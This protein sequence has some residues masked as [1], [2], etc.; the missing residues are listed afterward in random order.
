MFLC[1]RCTA[2]LQCEQCAGKQINSQQMGH[3]QYSRGGG[4]V[5]Q[6][7]SSP[8]SLG[9]PGPRLER[10]VG[11]P[12]ERGS[13][14]QYENIGPHY[15][16]SSL[17]AAPSPPVPSRHSAR[18]DMI[19]A[20]TR[21]PECFFQQQQAL[22]QRQQL[23]EQLQLIQLKMIQNK[24]EHLK[25][26]EMIQQ[27]AQ[28]PPLQDFHRSPTVQHSGAVLQS[29]VNP[30][31]PHPFPAATPFPVSSTFPQPSTFTSPSSPF[32]ISATTQSVFQVSPSHIPSTPTLSSAFSTSPR[33]DSSSTS[34]GLRTD[35]SVLESTRNHLAQCGWYHG[36][37]SWEESNSLLSRCQEGTFLL[38]DSRH[39][40]TMYSLSVNR[41]DNLG[42]TSIRI[43]FTGG[44][45][46]L[47]ADGS[48]RNLIPAFSSITE[49]IQF[50]VEK[51]GHL[52]SD[53][54]PDEKVKIFAPIVLKKPFYKSPPSLAHLARLAVNKQLA[55]AG[56]RAEVLDIPPKL[57][58]YI[59]AYPSSI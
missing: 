1:P 12:R 6:Y 54:K 19:S 29:S 44:M 25:G 57:Q 47:D 10:V 3:N 37:L 45:F 5:I 41:A 55:E 49:L 51:D 31:S 9:A 7:P 42:P 2:P 35:L 40:G 43:D 33:L 13:P 22:Q 28:Q 32:L 26:L 39:P 46:K 16:N 15:E 4:G 21:S 24:L 50:Y 11:A 59:N 30:F 38:R 56:K 27:Q 53:K 48:I 20:P 58:E 8:P 34:S 23:E 52:I 14:R 36:N 18:A 17:L